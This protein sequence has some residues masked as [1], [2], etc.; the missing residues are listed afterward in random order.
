LPLLLTMV[1]V[2][3]LLMVLLLLHVLLLGFQQMSE[4]GV[5]LPDTQVAVPPHFATSSAELSLLLLLSLVLILL[6]LLACAWCL[7]VQLK[8]LPKQHIPSSLITAANR[9]CSTRCC[10]HSCI[11]LCLL[12]LL[13]P[14]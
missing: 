11:L 14:L 5:L 7:A 1:S 13:L 12:Q 9:P 3:I 2:L 8:Q 6:L 4:A 10:Q